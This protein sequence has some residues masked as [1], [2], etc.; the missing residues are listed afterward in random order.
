MC[1]AQVLP[2]VQQ[3]IVSTEGTGGVVNQP[4]LAFVHAILDKQTHAIKLI[5]E[6]IVQFQTTTVTTPPLIVGIR[7][8][9]C[10]PFEIV[11]GS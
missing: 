10:L 8:F 6:E 3:C 11:L 7:V 9:P 5:K 2:V 1:W 4:K